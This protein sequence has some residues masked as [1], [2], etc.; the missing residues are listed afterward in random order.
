M[1]TSA[2]N[3]KLKLTFE[4]FDIEF[5]SNCGFDYV[6][7]SHGSFWNEKFRTK[8]CGPNGHGDYY[9]GN[10]DNL[11]NSIPG[12]FTSL[13]QTLVVR[14]HTDSSAVRSGFKAIWKE[15]CWTCQVQAN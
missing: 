10:G 2:W 11:G 15:A 5:H 13:G 9:N 3:K 4:S 8:F 12:P 7:I 6:E 14:M 1:E